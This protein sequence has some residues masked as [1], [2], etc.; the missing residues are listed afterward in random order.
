M[1]FPAP[2]TP[3]SPA[4]PVNPILGPVPADRPELPASWEYSHRTYLLRA[5]D[6]SSWSI[7]EGSDMLGVLMFIPAER[8][9][10]HGSWRVED[11]G[12]E[13][14]GVGTS[15]TSWEEAVASLADYRRG[16]TPRDR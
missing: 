8:G 1:S 9:D 7:V 14:L 6:A 13:I 3:E 16:A 5:E 2:S 15:W 10:E 4:R 11:P 12:H